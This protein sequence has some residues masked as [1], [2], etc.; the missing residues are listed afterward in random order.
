MIGHAGWL[1]PERTKGEV[2]NFWRRDASDV[3]GWREKMGWSKEY[4]EEL[5][6]GTDVAAY[7][8]SFLPWDKTRE[9]HLAGI[10]HWY[11]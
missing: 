11:V 9:H 8:A 3:L 5:W 6:G 10:P 1:L 2:V 4:E 7:Q